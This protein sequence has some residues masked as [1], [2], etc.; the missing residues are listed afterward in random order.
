MPDLDE[1]T[2]EAAGEL[3][4]KYFSGVK[5][6]VKV[7]DRFSD[8]RNYGW[9]PAKPRY[10]EA[11][12]PIIL[13]AIEK[14]KPAI[15]AEVLDEAAREAETWILRGDPIPERASWA[16]AIADGIRDMKNPVSSDNPWRRSRSLSR[17]E[18][19]A[20]YGPGPVPEIRASDDWADCP[21]CEAGISTRNLGGIIISGRC[22]VCCGTGRVLA[23]EKQHEAARAQ[24]A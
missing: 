12:A 4:D 14:A 5:M 8:S 9:R 20:L 23:V 17:E 7:D 13:A 16:R 10:V 22:S 1:I 3:A 21:N 2:R 24:E 18:W 11:I 15:R 6:R 19:D